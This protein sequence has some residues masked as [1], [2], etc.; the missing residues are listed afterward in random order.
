MQ[1]T[2]LTIGSVEVEVRFKPIKN[3]HL[4]VHPPYG[5]VTVS[6]PEFFDLE[7]EGLSDYQT[8]MDKA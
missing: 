3:L 2:Q 6:S 5:K 7:S 1:I 4:S 8:G